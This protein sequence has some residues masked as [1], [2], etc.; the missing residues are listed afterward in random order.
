MCALPVLR[1]I[2][3]MNETFGARVRQHRERR[4]LTLAEVAEQTKIKASLLDGLERDDISQWPAGIFRRAYVR[5]YAGAIGFDADKAVR[6]FLD[7]H[8]HG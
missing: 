7:A 2:T 4:G 1:Q 6:E 3:A 5:A 8:T